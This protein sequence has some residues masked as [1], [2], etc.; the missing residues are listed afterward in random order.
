M[1]NVVG[2]LKKTHIRFL[3]VDVVILVAILGETKVA[4]LNHIVLG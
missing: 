2:T 3:F 4:N 1:L